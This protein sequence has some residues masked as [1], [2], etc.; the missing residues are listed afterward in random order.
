MN[1]TSGLIENLNCWFN[2][3]FANSHPPLTKF[4]ETTVSFLDRT[5]ERVKEKRNCTYKPPDYPLDV[6]AELPDEFAYFEYT[7]DW[8]AE[9][10]QRG[11]RKGQMKSD[12]AHKKSVTSEEKSTKK[13]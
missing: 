9:P 5:I 7:V 1:K 3:Q 11:K 13:L 4:V 2:S 6:I 10:V 8:C 12:K